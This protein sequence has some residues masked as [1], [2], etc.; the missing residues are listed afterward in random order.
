MLEL[1]VQLIVAFAAFALA[2]F[3]GPSDAAGREP[4]SVQ[5]TVLRSDSAG[6]P[7]AGA[8]EDCED[9]ARLQSA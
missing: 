2:P 3:D 5:R 7:K 1:L 9:E 4:P 6:T 8:R